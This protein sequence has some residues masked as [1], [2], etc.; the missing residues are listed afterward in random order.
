MSRFNFRRI[1]S[2]PIS[3][4]PIVLAATAFYPVSVNASVV[5]T[6]GA[7]DFYFDLE[8]GNTF[9]VRT[10]AQSFG[11]DSML[12]FY[13]SG[14]Q[15]LAENDDYFGLDSYISYNIQQT[16]VYRL[17][18]GVC[19]GDPNRWY[20]QSYTFDV[21]SVPTNVPSTTTEPTTVPITAQPVETTTSAVISTTTTTELVT[22]TTSTEL[23]TTTT[24]TT[25]ESTT[26]TTEVPATTL[27]LPTLPEPPTTTTST[28]EPPTTTTVT[29]TT[30]PYI[31]LTTVPTM[32]TVASTTTSTVPRTTLP[33]PSTSVAST[34]SSVV[35]IPTTIAVTTTT[36]TPVVETEEILDVAGKSTEEIQSVVEELIASGVSKEEAVALAT[37][38]EV[39]QTVTSE[40]ASQIFDAID[41]GA[42]TEEQTE[43]LITAVQDAPE[44]VRS[45]FE[46]EINVFDNKFGSY[47]PVG[48]KVSVS[49]RKV[50][51]AATGVLFVAPTIST[52]PPSAPPSGSPSGTSPSGSPSGSDTKSDSKSRKHRRGSK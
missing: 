47:V 51:I 2:R 13:N 36:V 40:E 11:I 34:T 27:V 44:S 35:E 37:S 45:A 50:I 12:W 32:T 24:S 29:S 7:E 23:A 20:G 9:T 49:K 3:L 28:T 6:Y 5:S 46:S 22:T 25:I 14:N 38:P 10:T 43:Q 48:S 21:N 8:A 18:T 1:I 31:P 41:T 52:T 30:Q 26:T 33:E 19:C 4:L 15:L 39:L 16:G 42:L 17:R